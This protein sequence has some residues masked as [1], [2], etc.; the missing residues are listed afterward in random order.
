MRGAGIIL[1]F[2]STIIGGA[3]FGVR[4]GEEATDDGCRRWERFLSL[5]II[6]H[7]MMVKRA[8]RP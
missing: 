6:Q 4:G 5:D 3:E 1:L 8:L 2:G 7:V